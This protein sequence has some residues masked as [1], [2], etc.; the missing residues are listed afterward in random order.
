MYP[1]VA[2]LGSTRPFLY[3][4][5]YILGHSYHCGDC[6]QLHMNMRIPHPKLLQETSSA[7][8]CICIMT[9]IELTVAVI[10]I[11]LGVIINRW[12]D[13]E[14]AIQTHTGDKKWK[15]DVFRK[16]DATDNLYVKRK[17]PGS[18]RQTPCVCL[19]EEPVHACVCVRACMRTCIMK[20]KGDGKKERKRSLGR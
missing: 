19:H 13:K 6:L 3:K 15:H 8:T 2:I 10:Q 1:K 16:I 18:E 14:N 17:D 20:G 12:M 7:H 5:A 11:R 4:D 9:G